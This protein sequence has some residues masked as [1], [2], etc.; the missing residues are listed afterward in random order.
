M[1]NN[2]KNKGLTGLANLGNTC[3]LNSCIQL[4]SHTYELNDLFSKILNKNLNNTNDAMLVIEWNKLYQLMWKENCTIAPYAFVNS[5]QKIAKEK[6]VEL[7]TGFDQNDLPEFLI[8]L[9]DCFHNG[10]KRE[11]DI[12]ISGIA[13]NS[14]DKLA[15]ICYAMMK[16]MYS[17]D[18]SELI[19][20]FYGIQVSK[21]Q[22]ING[23]IKS[24]TPEPFSILSLPIPQQ[25]NNFSIFDCLNLYCK[26][27]L[28]EG[29]NAWYNES[30]NQK[31]SVVKNMCFWSLP[32]ILIIDLKRFTRYNKKINTLIT[33]P[34]VNVDF[35]KYVIGYNNNN[36]I[37]ELY[38]ICNHSGSCF[39][40]HYYAYV[41][42]ASNK[43]VSFND[44]IVKEVL[45][46]DLI[47]NKSYCFFYRK[48]K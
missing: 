17:K 33:T 27:E 21:L 23:E 26:S 42:T 1:W 28:L 47:T 24:I 30:T 31:E 20:L 32:E 37:Y 19:P 14:K 44:M 8:F 5:I 3:Y 9:I 13:E 25:S 11:V 22:D 10:F 36:Y 35:S 4:L 48:I 38:G 2:Y 39:G 18:Y 6:N 41:K 45:E 16:K 7:F 46:K 40:G 34:L 12:E 29:D 43:W 15:E